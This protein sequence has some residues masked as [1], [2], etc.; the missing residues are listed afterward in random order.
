MKT[1]NEKLEDWV[2]KKIENEFTDDVCL[3]L[4]HKTLRLDKDNEMGKTGLE[5]YVPITPKA[6]GL[7]R[8]F[9]IDGIGYDLFL[10]TWE[11]FEKMADVDHYNLTC[12]DDAVIIWARTDADRQRFESLQARLRANLKNPQ[13]MHDRAQKWINS[14]IELF[15]DTLFENR[16]HVI[17]QNAGYICDL[18]SIALAY[19]NGTFFHHGQSKQIE[20]LRKMANI[21]DNFV[22]CYKKVVLE[23]DPD[24]QK[25]L[26]HS[27]L[28]LA[29]EHV[30]SFEKKK[31]SRKRSPMEIADW[32]HELSYTW[33]RVYHFCE[34]DDPVSAYLWACMLQEELGQ[35]ANEYMVPMFDIL[36]AFDSE[37]LKFFAENAKKAESAIIKA[38]EA[39]GGKVDRYASID[40]FLEKNA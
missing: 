20:E 2:I 19:T 24:M 31:S 1:T 9:I 10:Q 29:K 30:K 18:L 14:A 27:L 22:E 4:D 25:K 23:K 40:E 28:Y 32:Y 21:P 26:C 5:G 34:T 35:V 37:N 38:I 13:L 33:R 15:A 16:V 3:L 7:A 11:R 39:D 17:R 6:H 8:T 36:S 12:L